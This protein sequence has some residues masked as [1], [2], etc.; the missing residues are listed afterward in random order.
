MAD[1]RYLNVKYNS[2]SNAEVN[3]SGITRLGGVQDAIKAKFSHTLP[4]TAAQIQLHDADDNLITDLDDIPSKYYEKIKNGGLALTI[5]PIPAPESSSSSV[6]AATDP[7]VIQQAIEGALEPELTAHFKAFQDAQLVD[8]CIVSPE[9]AFLPYSREKLKKIYVRLC[10]EEVFDLLVGGVEKG[11]KFFA[12]TG[13]PGIGKS[14]FFIYVLYRLMRARSVSTSQSSPSLLNTT[15]IVFQTS[16]N[17]ECFDLERQ[18]VFHVE[19]VEA[20]RLV[21]ESKTLYFVNESEEPAIPSSCATLFIASAVSEEYQQ[22]IKKARILKLC[23]PVWTALELKSCRKYCHSEVPEDLLLE[24]LWLFGGV[25]RYVFQSGT[26]VTHADLEAALADKDA[27]DSIR[28]VALDREMN[29]NIHMLMHMVVS[30]DGQYRYVNGTIASKQIGSKL[31]EK[32]PQQMMLI[33][34]EQLRQDELRMRF[35]Q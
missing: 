5:Q 10:Y 28:T 29:Y 2:S 18:E 30:D 16:E 7:A 19:D 21:R 14:P 23:F 20:A 17:Y 33:L 12:V 9:Q 26:S 25:P 27:V 11:F 1:D 6:N 34:Q 32:Y 15:R 8:S 22:L 35:Q 13:T 31:F 4:M 3:V 24:R